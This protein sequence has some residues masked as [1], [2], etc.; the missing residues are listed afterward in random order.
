MTIAFDPTLFAS[1]ALSWASLAALAG[2]AL[3]LALM[4]R[5]APRLGLTS[6][7]TYAV[8]LCGVLWG[9][10]GAR[11]LHVA[12]YAGFYAD[13]PFRAFYV[14]EGG[15]ALWGAVLAGS[16]GAVWHARRRGASVGRFADA[17]AVAGLAGM[18]VGRAG[19]F[20][21]G[22][23]PG[24]LT[25]LPWGVVYAHSRSE[26]FAAGAAV[27]PVALY[28]L[29]LDLAVL[30]LLLWGLS[31]RRA[32]SARRRADRLARALCRRFAR[33]AGRGRSRRGRLALWGGPLPHFVRADRPYAPGLAGGSV[34]GV[35]RARR[36][37][38]VC[39]AAPPPGGSLTRYH[40]RG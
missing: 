37:W 24:A 4:M 19:D 22:A 11:L 30:G 2:I 5:Q 18:A 33:A 31:L 10:L 9:L 29:V 8:G 7:D 26:A 39:V 34:G 36:R 35:G 13:A 40:V 15:L 21:A 3:G 32:L 17:L 25:S 6:R 14:W 16:A 1:S 12:D 20:I 28:E 27:H 23:T 38:R